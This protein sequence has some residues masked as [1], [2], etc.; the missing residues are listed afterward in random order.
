MKSKLLVLTL[1]AVAAG[2][3]V[4][5]LSACAPIDPPPTPHIHSYTAY[6]KDDVQHW[7]VCPEDGDIAPTSY[8]YHVY[9]DGVCV[10][11]KLDP[12]VEHVHDLADKWSANNDIHWHECSGCDE[13][14]DLAEHSTDSGEWEFEGFDAS[15][16]WHVCKVCKE[17]YD[18]D[19]HNILGKDSDASGHW[20]ICTRC[21][22]KVNFE[23]HDFSESDKCECGYDLAGT[24]GL[25]YEL[26]AQ[27]NTYVLKSIGS[28]TDANIVI[29]S[30]YNGKSVVE[31][32]AGAFNNCATVKSVRIPDTVTT[33]GASAFGG[34]TGLTGIV[35]PSAIRDVAESAFDNC[36]ALEAITIKGGEND[37]FTVIDGILYLKADTGSLS[38]RVVPLAVKGT[39]NIPDSIKTINAETF[40]GR[41]Q[42][43][44]VVFGEASEA[45]IIELSAFK[46]CSAL[47]EI[48]M[49]KR[50]KTLRS[51]AFQ[52]CKKLASIELPDS[53]T[54][55]EDWIFYGCSGLVSAKL[56][57]GLTKLSNLTF[58]RCS[59]LTE[60][61]IP[62]TVTAFGSQVFM[63][64]SALT[65]IRFA[66]GCRLA[67]IPMNTFMNCT[68]LR[69][70]D[71][72]DNVKKIGNTAFQNCL[73]L[74]EVTL[75]AGLQS[76]GMNAF[77]R[78]EKLA[79]V[80]IPDSVTQLADFAFNRCSV[81]KEVVFGAGST[82]KSIGNA[83]FAS[84]IALEYVV[85]P[86]LTVPE[87]GYS[88]GNNI[89]EGCT[90]LADIYYM[91]TA[92]EWAALTIDPKD[93]TLKT[94]ARLCF[95]VENE[96]DVPEDGG[97]Y[98]H[99]ADGKPV[100]W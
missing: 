24:E 43:K 7:S 45:T 17:K 28:A 89:L 19:V 95:Y 64:C 87:K 77:N 58:S 40:M 52:D 78:C 9:N 62:A 83:A 91:G 71:I 74:A 46:E 29:P 38:V 15:G 98:W 42:L 25:E 69:A 73:A 90:A 33:I 67:E 68:S 14:V 80:E 47:E 82:L 20:Q 23:E 10:C 76:I 39:V 55:F 86:K 57:A 6:G 36:T 5:G 81:L 11:G 31:I 60:I 93:T 65:E 34:C 27:K 4:A 51:Y 70:I 88:I 12:V 18:I 50:L 66:A 30:V 72:P 53:I 37:N 2:C 8:R 99:F 85:I 3:M 21:D 100:K 79:R 61:E 94:D 48:V 56:P 32:A 1:S 49:P 44:K 26:V 97:S 16:H 13:Y 84:C 96:A 63:G 75:P 92:E 22:F 41:K 35:L 59:S 54:Q